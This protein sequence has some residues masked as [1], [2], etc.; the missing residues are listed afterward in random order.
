MAGPLTANVPENIIVAV[1]VKGRMGICQY[2][3][4]GRGCFRLRRRDRKREPKN[5]QMRQGQGDDDEQV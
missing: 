2:S 3:R 1:E 4:R 5:N